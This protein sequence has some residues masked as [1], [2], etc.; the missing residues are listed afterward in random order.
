MSLY[1]DLKNPVHLDLGLV[2][3]ARR[4]RERESVVCVC[5][6]VC[7]CFS[8]KTYNKHLLWALRLPRRTQHRSFPQESSQL[9]SK[10]T[11]G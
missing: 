7:V 8:P 11:E 6:C 4:E 1:F 2:G 3:W 9:G 10:E 5:V